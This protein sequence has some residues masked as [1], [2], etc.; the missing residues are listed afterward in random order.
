[1][2]EVHGVNLKVKNSK[3]GTVSVVD[4]DYLK[5]SASANLKAEVSTN[6][7]G[8][9]TE[10]AEVQLTIP[11]ANGTDSTTAKHRKPARRDRPWSLRDC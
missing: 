9:Q 8:S 2:L 7:A 1:M 5:H 11:T 10:V 4:Y 6:E 3:T